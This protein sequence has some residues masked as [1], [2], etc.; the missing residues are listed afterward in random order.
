[1]RPICGIFIIDN[2]TGKYLRRSMWHCI[3]KSELNI[4]LLEYNKKN[5]KPLV[6]GML[7]LWV[8]LK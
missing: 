5:Y 6:M 2:Y 7:S 1:M 4:E 8:D 3:R